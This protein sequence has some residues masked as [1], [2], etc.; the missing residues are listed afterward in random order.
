MAEEGL[1]GSE[2]CLDAHLV[3]NLLHLGEHPRPAELADDDVV[4]PGTVVE[5]LRGRR[6]RGGPRVP[7]ELEGK[8]RTFLEAEEGGEAERRDLGGFLHAQEKSQRALGRG[9]RRGKIGGKD[10][11]SGVPDELF[12]GCTVHLI[13]VG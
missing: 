1:L 7:E 11:A 9:T 3:E 6:R 4:G 10:F 8:A 5:R 13:E 12:S 2:P